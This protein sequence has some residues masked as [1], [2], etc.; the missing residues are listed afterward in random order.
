MLNS[1]ESSNLHKQAQ[2][3]SRPRTGSLD[4]RWRQPAPRPQGIALAA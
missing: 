3:T 1:K 4:F 2:A